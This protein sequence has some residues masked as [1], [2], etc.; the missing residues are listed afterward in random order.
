MTSAHSPRDKIE[1]ASVY[2]PF[3]RTTD[4]CIWDIRPH[5]Y[6]LTHAQYVC[7]NKPEVASDKDGEEGRSHDESAEQKFDDV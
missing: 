5:T 7:V 2:I 6:V 3:L 4:L 1:Y